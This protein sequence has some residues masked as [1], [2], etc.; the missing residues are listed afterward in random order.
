VG[1]G[2]IKDQNDDPRPQTEAE[3]NVNHRMCQ[4]G[5]GHEEIAG[6][7]HHCANTETGAAGSNGTIARSGRRS[8]GISRGSQGTY[9]TD[10]GKVCGIDQ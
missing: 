7:S 5:A 8:F 10:P 3:D 9:S 1:Q 6:R 4:R 2:R